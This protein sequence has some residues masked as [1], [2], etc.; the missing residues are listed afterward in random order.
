VA[1][2][3]EYWQERC[4]QV[5]SDV[6]LFSLPSPRFRTVQVIGSERSRGT[7][8]W[9]AMLLVNPLLKERPL[10]PSGF[11]RGALIV[12]RRPQPNFTHRKLGA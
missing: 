11:D 10:G 1:Q 8:P 12:Q 3:I 4:R 9:G 6:G 7:L 2:S 5:P